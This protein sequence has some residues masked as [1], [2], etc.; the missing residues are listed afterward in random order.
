MVGDVTAALEA[1]RIE[2]Q[3][4]LATADRVGGQVEI[5]AAQQAVRDSAMAS[6]A[7]ASAL[8]EQVRLL[9][10]HLS[11]TATNVSTKASG[12]AD[13]LIVLMIAVAV[14]GVAGGFLAG[15]LLARFG[16][17]APLNRSVGQLE[18]LAAGR[19][20][21]EVTG[22]Q[23]GDE[24]GLIAKGLK[25][26]Q[27]GLRRQRQ[28]EAD[29]K[30]AEVRMQAERR[31]TMLEMADAFE[32]SV[33]GVVSAVSSAATEL[34]HSAQSMSAIAEQTNRQSGAV[35][36]ATEEASAN[37]QTVAA[38]TDE[39]TS[40]IAEISRQIVESSRI[41]REAVTHA[42]RS[43]EQVGRLAEAAQQIGAVVNLIQNIA[44]QTNLL[45]LN[46]TIE[47]ARAGEAGKGFA[48]VASEV[49]TLA[50][51]TA[52][53]TDE[54]SQQ[55]AGIQAQAQEAVDV[56]RGIASIIG[57]VNEISGSIAAAMEEQTAATQ[58]I[59]RNVQQAAQG[60][61]EVATNITGVSHAAA[62]SGT[63]ASQVLGAAGQLSSEANQL[64]TKVDAFIQE[65]RAA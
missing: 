35:A 30:E 52:R 38:A 12:T 24:I 32:K 39:L 57:R 62:E 51:Q 50:T 43:S 63:A 44:S 49:K 4:T 56:I 10:T 26:F 58:E 31:R 19:L 29:A 2:L 41:S 7:K 59:G 45:A 33:K 61:Q 65:I 40:S 22:D 55:I 34:E 15:F 25:I 60:T 13:T 20:D 28:M 46:A 27:E 42:S 47:A 14:G 21:V 16:I 8:Q 17:V 64:S 18:A 53:A 5:S 37:V 23:R 48:V 1:Y 9:A 54:I 6:R 36:S 11:D 3:G